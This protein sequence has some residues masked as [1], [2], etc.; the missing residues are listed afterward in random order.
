MNAN[1][2]Q[3]SITHR[4]VIGGIL[5]FALIEVD[6]LYG[7]AVVAPT[8]GFGSVIYTVGSL[9]FMLL[10]MNVFGR[11]LPISICLCVLTFYWFSIFLDYFILFP[12]AVSQESVISAVLFYVIHCATQVLIVKFW[13]I[14]FFK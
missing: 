12:G 3:K 6:H 11:I 14:D 9:F 4:D 2:K 1:Q 5:F 7:A 10:L 13:E 8:G